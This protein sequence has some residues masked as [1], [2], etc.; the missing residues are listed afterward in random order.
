MQGPKKRRSDGAA[1]KILI[2]P[3]IRLFIVQPS[4]GPALLDGSHL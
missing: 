1:A 3:L 4:L 2:C